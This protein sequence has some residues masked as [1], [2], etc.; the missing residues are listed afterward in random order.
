M[1]R[2]P[3]SKVS[4]RADGC[5]WKHS[6][7]KRGGPIQ[8]TTS[9]IVLSILRRCK[10]GAYFTKTSPLLE[11]SSKVSGSSF[12]AD[13]FSFRTF[14]SHPF[15]SESSLSRSITQD[16]VSSNHFTTSL[17]AFERSTVR[18]SVT[19]ESLSLFKVSPHRLTSSLEEAC[20]TTRTCS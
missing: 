17:G 6:S 11:S 2:A 14:N 16:A 15:G 19:F 1:E 9:K 8:K 10:D 20:A 13:P 18:T 4:R 5:P 12:D 3:G 7:R